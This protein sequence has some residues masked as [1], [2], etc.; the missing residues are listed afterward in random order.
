MSNPRWLEDLGQAWPLGHEYRSWPESTTSS[1]E[2]VSFLVSPGHIASIV[3][4]QCSSIPPNAVMFVATVLAQHLHQTLLPNSRQA[5]SLWTIDGLQP[6][7]CPHH[8]NSLDMSHV[9]PSDRHLGLRYPFQIRQHL[10]KM[11]DGSCTCT[12]LFESNVQPD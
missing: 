5:S 9:L 1:H 6:L 7:A 3:D 2:S 12:I 11:H 4:I 8:A 10:T